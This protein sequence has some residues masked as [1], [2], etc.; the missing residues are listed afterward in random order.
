MSESWPMGLLFY[1]RES[2]LWLPVCLPAHK[3][4]VQ[5]VS[6]EILFFVVVFFLFFCLFV[7]CCCF[8]FF[9]FLF[10][11]LFCF[12]LF[13]FLFVFFCG[14][15]GG[16]C[17]CCCCFMSL[18]PYSMLEEACYCGLFLKS[19]HHFTLPCIEVLTLFHISHAVF[20][21]GKTA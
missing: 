9:F 20:F 16:V 12:V 17:C 11:F 4:F 6:E 10:F 14:G 21:R 13:F 8:F 2:L 15:G 7:F 18:S 5:S 1:T 3:V 19:P